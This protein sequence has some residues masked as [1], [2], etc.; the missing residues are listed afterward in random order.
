MHGSKV[1]SDE[2]IKKKEHLISRK[3]TKIV[4]AAFPRGRRRNQTSHRKLKGRRGEP[5][6]RWRTGKHVYHVQRREDKT[7]EEIT[8]NSM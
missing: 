4:R 5:A 8:C 7:M 6:T 3:I 2:P 1:T